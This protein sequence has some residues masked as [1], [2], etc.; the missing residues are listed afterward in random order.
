MGNKDFMWICECV[1]DKLVFSGGVCKFE[2]IN[3]GVNGK[4]DDKGDCG[5]KVMGVIYYED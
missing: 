1:G 4:V 3:C 2:F 5:C